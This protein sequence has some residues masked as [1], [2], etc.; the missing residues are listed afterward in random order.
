MVK[1]Q[2]AGMQKRSLQ[3]LCRSLQFFRK[4]PHP[5]RSVNG[6]T[7]YGVSLLCQVNS[8]LMCSSS[9]NPDPEQRNG[10]VA[11][12]D[13]IVG[14][15]CSFSAGSD[16]NFCAV[17]G[18]SAQR[19]VHCSGRWG[20]TSV[21]QG[22][23]FLMNFPVFELLR[24]L[25]V[26]QLVFCDQ[27]HAASQLVQSMDNA[28]P[29]RIAGFQLPHVVQ[30]RIHECPRTHASSGV[31]DKAC[32]FVNNRKVRILIQDVQG[33]FF[34]EGLVRK[35]LWYLQLDPVVELRPIAGFDM[36]AVYSQI[37]LADPGL[38]L[39]TALPGDPFDQKLIQSNPCG[40]Q[41]NIP[42]F[43]IFVQF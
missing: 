25:P 31:A 14:Y 23:V 18:V 41:P 2:Q 36:L 22:R 43:Y 8:N 38:D 24:E 26:R 30:Q 37:S 29:C 13:G 5:V 10:A 27:H 35:I 34:R 42:A 1:L 33:D 17:S 28:W 15:G 40:I 11:L 3:F 6:I 12:F 20:G 39:R 19:Q 32:W 4:A 7:D 16:G 9:L 21:D